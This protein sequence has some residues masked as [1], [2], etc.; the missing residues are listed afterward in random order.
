MFFNLEKGWQVQTPPEI[1]H[2]KFFIYLYEF[3]YIYM[4][5]YWGLFCLQDADILIYDIN[6]NFI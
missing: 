1:L 2:A 6:Y 3:L 4:N 5:K